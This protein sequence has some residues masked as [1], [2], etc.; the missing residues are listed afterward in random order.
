MKNLSS[1]NHK[2]IAGQYPNNRDNLEE[3]KDVRG[4]TRHYRT[5]E[6]PDDVFQQRLDDEFSGRAE[7][8]KE[9][10]LDDVWLDALMKNKSKER[11]REPAFAFTVVKK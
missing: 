1:K 2:K 6:T 11:H 3:T 9:Q 7:K 4:L 10:R 5:N 8:E